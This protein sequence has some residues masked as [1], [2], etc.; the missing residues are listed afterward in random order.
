MKDA[1]YEL[2]K[3]ESFEKSKK[4]KKKFIEGIED[5]IGSENILM[6]RA[7]DMALQTARIDCLNAHVYISNEKNLWSI[8]IDKLEEY[9]ISISR[10]DNS[11]MPTQEKETTKIVLNKV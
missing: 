3:H 5:V 6:I 9:K 10:I 2:K 4:D 8:D 11:F 1:N 7:R